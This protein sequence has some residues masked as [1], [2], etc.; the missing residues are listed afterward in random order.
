VAENQ[1]ERPPREIWQGAA[2][3]QDLS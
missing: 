1:A 3:C 2:K